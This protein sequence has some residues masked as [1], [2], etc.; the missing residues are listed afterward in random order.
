M[1]IIDLSHW[2]GVVDFA[3]V[4]KDG[5]EAVIMKC[6]QGTAMFDN[7][8]AKNKADARKA[9]LLCGFY[10]FANGSD[11]IKEADWFVKTVGD[12][13]EGE[14]VVLDFE[15]DI[16]KPAEWCKA[17]LDRVS[18]K[19]GFKPLLY[20]NEARIIAI[21]FKIVSDADYGLWIAKYGDN[22]DKAEANEVPNTD[23]WKFYAI[24]QFSSTGKVGG[25]S[26][27]VNLNTTDMD[28]KT[29]K[30][31][32]KPA[33]TAESET[34]KDYS[35]NLYKIFGAVE[36][37]LGGKFGENPSDKET[38]DIIQALSDIKKR[39]D[40]P[41]V[42]TVTVE[43]EV[44]KIVYKDSPETLAKIEN[45]RVQITSLLAKIANGESLLKK[46][47]QSIVNFFKV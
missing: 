40:A 34:K 29:L 39:M 35:D 31:Y 23:E 12:L 42:K 22:D 45:Q 17:W 10:H 5:V 19:L 24:W 21:D 13:Q 18:S 44:E 20:S 37:L 6:T 25:I 43:K 14:F 33:I 28:L 1:K 7:N 46:I 27:R 4:K 16:A 9:G 32:G 36:D 8:F 15:I 26:G 30:K 11:S 41:Q 47:G 38:A 2:N 3:K